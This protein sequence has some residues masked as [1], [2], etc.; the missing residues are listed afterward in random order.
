MKS[1]TASVTVANYLVS[2]IEELGIKVIPV[3][4]GGVIMKMIDEV[5]E[6]KVLSYIVPNHEQALAM[7]VDSYARIN[8][9]GVGFTTGG[10][11]AVNL[12][13]GI[14]CA[15]Y[16]SVPCLFITGQVGMFHSTG[17][18]N[19]RQRGFQ[20]T[21]IVSVLS[22]I[23]KYAILL[24]KAE[25]ARYIFEKA[26][27][28]SK[29]GR[30]G[31]V[32]IDL[33]Y[34]VQRS[35]VI[36]KQLQGYDPGTE[37]IVSQKDKNLILSNAGNALRKA[38]PISYNHTMASANLIINKISKAKK[39][40]LLVGGGVR[41]SGKQED[42]YRFV[43]KSGIPV[44][45]TWTSADF[46][47]RDFY[48]YLGNVGKSGD[49]VAVSAVQDCDLLVCLG[50]RFTPKVIINEKRFAE[51]AEIIAVDIDCAE[52]NEAIIDPNF[53]IVADLKSLLPDLVDATNYN[54]LISEEW[55]RTLTK[56]KVKLAFTPELSDKVDKYVNPFNFAE[57]LFQAMETDA[58]LFADAGANLTWIMQGCKLKRGQRLISAWG[59]SPMGYA[60]PAAIGA[61]LAAPDQQ[62]IATIGDGGFQMNIQE[63]Q[64]M[65]GNKIDI[66]LF[67]LNNR[68]YGNIKMGARRE[69]NSRVHGNDSNSGYTAP[70]FIKVAQAYGLQTE[71]IDNDAEVSQKLS[72]ILATKGA[73]IVD[74]NI[75]PEQEH[76]ELNI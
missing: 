46:F 65:F 4:Q 17:E 5:G 12:A 75:D 8:G 69:F 50:S 16:D 64:T 42:A 45:T 3:L 68:C 31:P 35:L 58:I 18:R 47:P 28:I 10:P 26:V 56:M 29:N 44:V 38:L 73:L 54:L 71:T 27:Y 39:P 74:V 6:S 57:K 52:L 40:L 2:R 66:K 1:S 32:V 22:P 67:I 61:K 41:I 70:N 49:N 63:L 55:I 21:D 15:Y 37:A 43:E 51:K 19:V 59:N 25:D 14:A 24:E 13:T 23:T 9:Y 53:K 7:M 76:V 36:P 72:K 11:G 34:N 62:I 20:E 30:P 60:F 48:L 33:P